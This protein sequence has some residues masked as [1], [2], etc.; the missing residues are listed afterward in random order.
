MIKE[1]RYIVIKGIIVSFLLFFFALAIL[2][3]LV[4]L[5][6]NTPDDLKDFALNEVYL[7]TKSMRYMTIEVFYWIFK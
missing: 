3:K 6:T 2:S 4:L 1:R 7:F 5:Q